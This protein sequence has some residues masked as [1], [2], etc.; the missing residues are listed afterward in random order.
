MK[1]KE[2]RQLKPAHV[3]APVSKTN[4]EQLKLTLQA[5]R[6]RC[7]EL[8]KELNEMREELRKSNIEVD[9]ELSN[10]LTKILGSADAAKITPFMSLFW[11]QQQKL[12]SSSKTGVRYHPMIIRFCLSLAAKSPS[13]YEELRNSGILVFPSQRRLR[14]YRNAIKPQRGF[15]EEVIQVLKTETDRYFDVQRYVV[16]LFDEIKVLAN[17]VLDKV[18][19]ELIG[20]TDLGDP[21]I[22]FAAL[23]KV[24]D[25]AT[26]ALVFLVRGICT[27]L[28][29][30]LAHFA[31][32][33]ITTAQL[34]PIFWEAV[35]ILEATCNLWVVAATDGAS[36]NRRF[37]RLHK[38]LDG[39]AE[40]EV[41]YRTINLYA[42]HR[43]SV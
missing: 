16:L 32:K 42:P 13:S 40:G 6:L 17:L 29:F 12:F 21:D 14:D 8:E 24:D 9:H 30:C 27:E 35:C 5:Q 34:L 25:I 7:A 15:Q 1:A 3:N 28:K 4:P 26:H 37:F 39:G 36:P 41:C 2:S 20:L 22:I 23:E 11:Q 31:T 18:T 43:Y 38:Q 33:G 10:D 19:G